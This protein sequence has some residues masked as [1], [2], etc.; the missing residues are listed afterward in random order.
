M[1]AN[2]TRREVHVVKFNSQIYLGKAL[3]LFFKLVNSV[4][5]QEGFRTLYSIELKKALL[6]T[7]C[8]IELA[9]SIWAACSEPAVGDSRI[10]A[11]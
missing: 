8:I 3:S 4:F 11:V 7:Y 10:A 2:M 5:P 9:E 6:C 1:A